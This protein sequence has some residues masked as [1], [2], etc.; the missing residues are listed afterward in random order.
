MRTQAPVAAVYGID[1]GK[2]YFHVVGTDPTGKP[3]RRTKLTRS[4]IFEFFANAPAATIGMEA[5][6]GSQWLARKL[7]ALGHTVKIIPA[8]FVKPYV[9]AN[10]NDT[11]DAAAIAEAVTRPTMRFVQMKHTEQVDLQALHRARD[12]IV[13]LNRPGF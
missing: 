4:N 10:K 8:Q 12:L 13:S 1:L 9:K 3:V 2:T 7:S 5:C 11:I 6:P